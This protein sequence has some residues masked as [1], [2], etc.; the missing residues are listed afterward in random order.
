M[1]LT[2]KTRI[3][4]ERMTPHIVQLWR[5]LVPLQT[6][7]S[8]MN[9]GAHPDDEVSSMLA[10]LSLRDG[11]NIS[12]ACSTRGEGGQNDIG[13]EST[14]AL[15]TLRTAEM[16]RA[17][18]VLNMRMYWHCDSLDDTIFDFGFSKSGDETMAKWGHARTLK[19][20]VEII[21]IERPDI[22][23]P[24]FL[25]ISGQ[26]GH[27]RAMTKAAHL[28]MDL[29]ADRDYPDSD[30]QPWQVKKLYLP[31]WSGAGQAYDDDLPPPPATLT[32]DATGMDP[33]TGHS[34]AR[35]GQQSRVFH[36]TQAM[37]R[38]VPAG[39]E[40]DWPLHLADSRVSGPDTNLSAGLPVTLADFNVPEIMPVLE[41]AQAHMDKARAAFPDTEEI[42][43]HAAAALGALQEAIANCP[44][45]ARPQIMHKLRRK[46]TQLSNLL[47]IACRVEVIARTDTDW[48]R[49]G[50]TAQLAIETRQGIAEKLS[51]TPVLPNGWAL[52][53]TSLQIDET[54]EIS[55]PYPSIYLPDTPAAPCLSVEIA[56]HGVTARSYTNLEVRPTVLPA[57]SAVLGHITDVINTSTNKRK[58]NI[59]LSDINPQGA[60]PDLVV[61]GGWKVSKTDAGFSVTA[62]LEIDPGLYTLALTLD[63]K[64]AQ[65]LHRISYPHVAPRML[66]SPAEIRVRVVNAILPNTRVGYIG[67]GNDRVDYWLGR[68]G[69]DV[70]P[71]NDG[72]LQSD[73]ALEGFG[74]LIIGIFAMKSREALL[75]QMPRLHNWC[76]QGG[77][78]LTLYHRPWDNWDPD[79]VPPKQLEIGQPSL[80]WRVTD[81]T[82]KVTMLE[83][84]HPLLNMPNKIADADWSGWHK[85]R[86]LYFA[87]SWDAA[88]TPLLAMN[89]PG[90][91][92]LHGSLLVADIGAGRHIYTSLILHYQMEKLTA[93]S[94]RIMANLLS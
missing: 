32:I 8:F 94:F 38:W 28:V 87:K 78:L 44:T 58:I 90:E 63:G 71:L 85:E 50:D 61:P 66:C 24:T 79:T 59:T 53:G 15:G 5:A 37:G 62:P 47:R 68:M 77:T 56:T 42:T 40:Q 41:T 26:H 34:F 89:D 82:A 73:K 93:G 72:D 67:G 88:Y 45:N 6:V 3:L 36:A 91:D 9:T 11:I 54:A 86:G 14:H 13:T 80:R 19:R 30:L 20:F 29:A 52:S 69:V 70:T 43:R 83:P 21:R 7:V 74:T 10:A 25:D 92:P 35:I 84:N 18:D 55:D 1:P 64:P 27:H 76:K 57:Y 33:V 22:I 75:D 31:A 46:E 4:A 12:Y 48:L 60:H 81:E 51:I 39:D 16:E 17:C 2:D 23:C 49:P 65:T